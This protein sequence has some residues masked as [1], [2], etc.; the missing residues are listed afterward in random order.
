[1]SLDLLG[2]KKKLSQKI[3]MFNHLHRRMRMRLCWVA[4]IF[5]VLCDRKESELFPEAAD[6]RKVNDR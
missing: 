3:A 6:G 2:G 5:I 4:C 1:M